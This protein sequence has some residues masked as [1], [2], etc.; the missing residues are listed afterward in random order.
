MIIAK[1]VYKKYQGGARKWILEDVNFVIPD[2][3][4]VGLIGHNGAGKSTLL[5]MIGGIEEPTKGSIVRTS[6]VSWTMGFGGG[7]QGSLTGR[8][9]AKF[10]CRIL[11]Y[12]EQMSDIIKFIEDF[13]EIGVSFDKP[14]NSY[15]VGMKS[16]LQFGMSLA[17]KFDVYISDE[18]TSTGDANF[19]KKQA[20]LLKN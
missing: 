18:V 9:N 7:L 16:R 20:K 13:A 11:G 4:S 6:N 17:F 14:V 5:R 2:K 12:E 10:V 3:V 19:K 15:S 1:N 8:Q